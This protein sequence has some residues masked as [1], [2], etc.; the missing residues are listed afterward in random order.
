MLGPGLEERKLQSGEQQNRGVFPKHHSRIQHAM[1]K[2]VI[3]SIQSV[4][5]CKASRKPFAN[6]AV[7]ELESWKILRGE[8]QPDNA[9]IAQNY[10]NQR[11]H[12]GSPLDLARDE[13]PDDIKPEDRS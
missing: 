8:I 1:N 4:L 10:H 5:Q 7:A 2:A 9:A 12:A 6:S 11:E 3:F 13:D